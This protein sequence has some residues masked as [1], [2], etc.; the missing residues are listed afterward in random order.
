MNRSIQV[1]E[2]FAVLIEDMKLYKLK[3]KGKESAKRKIEVFSI[4][5]NFNRY[6]TKLIRKSWK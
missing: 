1:G 5:Y 6:L 2:A 4:A 3:V